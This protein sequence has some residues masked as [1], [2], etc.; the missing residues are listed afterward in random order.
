M[1]T[2]KKI[3]MSVSAICLLVV[4]GVLAVAI[5]F[6]AINNTTNSNIKVTYTANQISGTA[7]AFYGVSGD[8][9]WSNMYVDGN[10]EKATS[11]DFS[12]EKGEVT[13]TLSPATTNNEV[14]VTATKTYAVFKYVFTNSSTANKIDVNLTDNKV[15]TPTNFTV[16]YLATG[17]DYGISD[18]YTQLKSSGTEAYSETQVPAKVDTTVGI[19]YIYVLV[20]L[21]DDTIDAEFTAEFSWVLTKGEAISA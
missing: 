11:V 21:V 15:Q 2:K 7:T 9:S 17:Q 13:T 20:E 14:T 6:A 5:V 4:A 16:K 10:S 12:A 1:A 3:I 19:Q 8:A 18:A